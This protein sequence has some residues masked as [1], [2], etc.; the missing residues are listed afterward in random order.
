VWLASAQADWINLSGADNAPTIAEICIQEDHVRLVLEIY[1]G[2]LVKFEQLLPDKFFRDNDIN[3]SRPALAERLRLFSEETFQFV[4]EGGENLQAQLKLIE[5][6]LRKERLSPF[7]GMI[8]PMTGRPVPGTP[9]DKRVFYAELVYPFETKPRILT[10]IPPLEKNGLPSVSI[11]FI[12][13]HKEAPIIDFKCLSSASKVNLG[14]EDPWYTAFED[15]ALKRW[16]TS[17]VQSFIYIEPF[18]V[19]HEIL[20]R[21]RDL[22]AWMSLELRGDEFIEVDE[23]NSL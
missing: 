15:R 2:D 3:I 4:T 20:V 19:R 12:A 18:E 16:Q 5:P 22:A 6:R 23:F 10:I 9:E 8:N 17:G 13:Y 21:V 14:W 1:V 7:A 11:G